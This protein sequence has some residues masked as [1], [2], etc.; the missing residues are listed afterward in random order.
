VDGPADAGTVAAVTA[1]C[2]AAGAMP[3]ELST[4]GTSLAEAYF[5]LTARAEDPA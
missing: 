1:W 3:T 4:S 5:T 2:A